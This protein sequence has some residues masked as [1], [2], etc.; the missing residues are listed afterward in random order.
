MARIRPSRSRA[1]S[2]TSRPSR[3]PSRTILPRRLSRSRNDSFGVPSSAVTS[4]SSSRPKRPTRFCW[5]RRAAVSRS[6][7]RASAAR[8]SRY[9]SGSWPPWRPVHHA[10]PTTSRP[11]ISSRTR[12]LR[13]AAELIL[14]GQTP[15]LARSQPVFAA[16]EPDHAAGECRDHAPED[17]LAPP[18]VELRHVPRAGLGVEV[19]AVDAGELSGSLLLRSR[20]AR[21]SVHRRRLYDAHRQGRRLAAGV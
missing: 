14:R 11:R 20:V 18:P 3:R 10:V 8:A 5:A 2:C 1:S 19:H 17:R 4:S 7:S 13:I 9:Q 21:R 12:A 6:G 15:G 16:E